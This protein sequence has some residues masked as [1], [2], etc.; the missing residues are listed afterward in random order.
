MN[1]QSTLVT[2]RRGFLRAAATTAVAAGAVGAVPAAAAQADEAATFAAWFDGVDNYEG[3][4]DRT[5]ESAVTVT[6][7]A[8][9][10]GGGFAYGPAAVRV[11]P[12]TAVTWEWT[13]EG[14]GHDVVD[15]AGAYASELVSAAGETFTHTFEAEGVSYYACTPHKPMGM[16]GA[17]VVGTVLVGGSATE[18]P[19]PNYGDWFDGVDNFDGTVDATGL[20]EVRVTVGASGNGGAFAFEPAAVRVD[21]GTTVVWEWAGD[22][23]H[24]VAAAD[25]SYS[26]PEAGGAFAMRFDGDGISKYACPTHG[27]AGM[28]GAVVVGAGGVT[29]TTPTAQGWLAG[30]LLGVVLGAPFLYGLYAHIADTTGQEPLA[31][32][33]VQRGGP[34]PRAEVQQREKGRRPGGGSL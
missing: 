7:G 21:P 13:G 5:G 33:P 28:R 23:G 17:V 27:D 29:R 25:G 20:D 24:G 30:G 22:R 12:G 8:P 16:R 10:N 1:S 19:E 32:E 14:G 26:S 9:G 6:V 2:G 34:I 3:V 31:A 18:Y 4:V 15:E 11:D